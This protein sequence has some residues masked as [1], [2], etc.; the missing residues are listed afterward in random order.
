[1]NDY[2][3][4]FNDGYKKA[5]EQQNEN[6]EMIVYID[7]RKIARTAEELEPQIALL[8]EKKKRTE[9]SFRA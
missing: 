2:L 3:Q 8:Q 9:K 5:M 1:M 6:T 7:G 4:G